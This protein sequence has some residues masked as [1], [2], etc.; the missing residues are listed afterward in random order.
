MLSLRQQ[1]LQLD[2]FDLEVEF[3]SARIAVSK[4]QI[5]DNKSTDIAMNSVMESFS[6]VFVV[7]IKSE[8]C[9]VITDVLGD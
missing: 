5:R 6:R 7:C 4:V 9:S 3:P 8:V 2:E 1:T